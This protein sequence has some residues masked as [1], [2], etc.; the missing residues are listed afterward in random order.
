MSRDSI[1]QRQA[2]IVRQVLGMDNWADRYQFIMEQGE[3]VPRLPVCWRTSANRVPDCASR[4]WVRGSGDAGRLGFLGASDC[5]MDAG[6]LGLVVHLFSGEAA[7]DI[8]AT[9]PRFI[10]EM[11]LPGRMSA[12]RIRGAYAMVHHVRHIAIRHLLGQRPVAFGSRPARV[13][14]RLAG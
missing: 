5:P 6:L 9:P 3:R 12:Q 13:P 7:N 2:R 11:G 10:E 8:I 14:S 1:E 4:V